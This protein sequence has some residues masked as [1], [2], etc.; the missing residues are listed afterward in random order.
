MDWACWRKKSNAALNWN[1]RA[2]LCC[3]NSHL[4]PKSFEIFQRAKYNQGKSKWKS[5]EV[6]LNQH[7]DQSFL[8]T[9][10]LL[11]HFKG[12]KETFTSC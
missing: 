3:Q 6:F 9:H 1:C 4:I 11:Y 10:E 8:R 7:E 5:L 2:T 12:I